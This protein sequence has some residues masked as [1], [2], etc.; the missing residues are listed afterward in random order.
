[1]TGRPRV[2]VVVLSYNRPTLLKEALSSI[3]RQ[4]LPNLEVLVVDNLSPASGQIE[5]VVGAFPGVRFLPQAVNRGFA[6][7]MNVGMAAAAG[8]FLHLTED[9]IVLE[10][11]F[12]DRLLPHAEARPRALF[13]G[14]V[15]DQPWVGHHYKGVTLEIGRRYVQ[16]PLE[17]PE[18]TD[19]YPVGMLT[20]AMMFGRREAFKVVGGF[21]RSFRVLRRRRI[22]PALGG[23]GRTAG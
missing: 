23:R 22:Q 7:G 15:R 6:A 1:M 4:Q 20:G 18:G 16:A 17:P 14:I 8:E 12:Y 13:S 19:P 2:S 3:I 9:D 21:A 5:K 11:G 10:H